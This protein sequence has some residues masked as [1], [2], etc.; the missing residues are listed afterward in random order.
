MK[1]YC[2]VSFVILLTIYADFPVFAQTGRIEKEINGWGFYKYRLNGEKIREKDLLGQIQHNQF[3][4]QTLQEAHRSKTWSQIF[5][6]TGLAV[7]SYQLIYRRKNNNE[8]SEEVLL[9]SV[10]A[11]AA[12]FT[13]IFRAG[14]KADLAVDYYNRGIAKSS[15]KNSPKFE[16]GLAGSGFGLQMKF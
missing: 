6:G 12:G 7:N 10:G 15:F 13:L 4:Y 1:R 2:F 9:V 11:L 5:I 14:A 16:I 3:A 8:I